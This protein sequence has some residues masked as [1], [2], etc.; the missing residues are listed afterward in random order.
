MSPTT[1]ENAQ[2]IKELDKSVD[3]YKESHN[4]IH[5]QQASS[6]ATMEATLAAINGTV[7]EV[8]ADQKLMSATLSGMAPLV[9]S[10]SK[11][12]L[13]ALKKEQET[14]KEF[15]WRTI[16]ITSV[17]AVVAIAIVSALVNYGFK[18]IESEKY[19]ERDEIQNIYKFSESLGV[20]EVETYICEDDED[21]NCEK[22]EKE[23]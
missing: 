23:K 2:D 14:N 13:P 12:D 8:R 16:G 10:I 20:S 22:E 15:R 3:M 11:I 9:D 21:E 19:I 17:A 5:R 6:M 4:N 7:Q 1:T 18:S